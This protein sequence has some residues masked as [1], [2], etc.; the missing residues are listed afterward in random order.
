MAGGDALHHQAGT[1]HSTA[2]SGNIWANDKLQGDHTSFQWIVG[3]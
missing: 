2:G 3:Y 1:A